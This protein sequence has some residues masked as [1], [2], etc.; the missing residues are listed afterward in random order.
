I[1]SSYPFSDFAYSPGGGPASAA[2]V[3]FCAS[4]GYTSISFTTKSLSVPVVDAM[5]WA[6]SSPVTVRSRSSGRVTHV[7][8]SGR[9][10]T[11]RWSA[12]SHRRQSPLGY[13]GEIGRARYGT[14]FAGSDT[15]SVYVLPAAGASNERTPFGWRYSLVAS[16]GGGH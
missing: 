3:F 8:T 9:L 7:A 6:E 4:S 10:S 14:G 5:S 12:T 11:N 13:V 1:G 2:H 15:Y 16:D